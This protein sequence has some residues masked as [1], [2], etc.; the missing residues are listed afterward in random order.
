MG[1]DLLLRQPNELTNCLGTFK[2]LTPPA[3]LFGSFIRLRN[4]AAGTP[5][6]LFF[7]LCAAQER[8]AVFL[9]QT[10]FF[11]PL[12]GT[13]EKLSEL[14]GEFLPSRVTNNDF[15]ALFDLFRTFFVQSRW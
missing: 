13:K 6:V 11:P 1:C 3:F 2:H 9:G 7:L 10:R 12:V 14:Q 8:V 15:P 4:T 5:P